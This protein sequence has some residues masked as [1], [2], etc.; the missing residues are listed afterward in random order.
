M[1][2]SQ[3]SQRLP[4]HSLLLLKSQLSLHGRSQR[5][6]LHR[7]LP[8]QLR[9]HSL[10]S[11]RQIRR[12]HHSHNQHLLHRLD[13]SQLLHLSSQVSHS[14]SSLGHNLK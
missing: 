4:L 1:F 3:R 9:R 7:R 14:H 5:H 2:L 12:R 6:S 8:S 10:S 13:L 11:L